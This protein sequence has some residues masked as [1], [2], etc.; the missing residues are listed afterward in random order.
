MS[1]K[2]DHP[3]D[4]IFEVKTFVNQLSEVQEERFL[5]LAERLGLN[6]RGR[7]LLFDYVYNCEDPVCFDEYLA[8]LGVSLHEFEVRPRGS[9]KPAKKRVSA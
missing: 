5:R 1:K 8:A 3:E 9:K 4:L 2:T 6:E 7:D